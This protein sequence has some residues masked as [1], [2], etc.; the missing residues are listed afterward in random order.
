MLYDVDNAFCEKGS[1][2]GDEDPEII[3]G[4]IDLG[5]EDLDIGEGEQIELVV[6]VTEGFTAGAGALTVGAFKAYTDDTITGTMGDDA[7][8]TADTLLCSTGEIAVAEL[9]AGAVF[10]VYIS[11]GECQRYVRLNFDMDD[12]ASDG[13]VTAYL[14]PR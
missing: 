13:A 2:I 14:A 8:L 1:C 9:V 3:L 5:E 10:K 12:A 4:I 6:V 7:E 11:P